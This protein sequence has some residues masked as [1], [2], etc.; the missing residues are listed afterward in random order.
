VNKLY[1][2]INLGQPIAAC[3]ILYAARKLWHR[4]KCQLNYM[5]DQY[6][7]ANKAMQGQC[8]VAL[9]RLIVRTMAADLRFRMGHWMCMAI[10]RCATMGPS[11]TQWP[12]RDPCGTRITCRSGG[13]AEK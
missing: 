1:Q 11:N 7:W 3:V 13:T 8:K 5:D 12:L 6:A 4:L 10:G 2:A 9:H